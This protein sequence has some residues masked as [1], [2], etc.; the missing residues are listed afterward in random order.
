MTR[1]EM[2]YVATNALKYNGES[3]E[4]TVPT[5]NIPD[6]SSCGAYRASV[7]FAYSTGVLMGVDASGAFDPNGTLSR[8]AAATVAVR[9]VDKSFRGT[10]NFEV[11]QGVQTWTEGEQHDIPKVGDKITTKS[12]QTYTIEM[13]YGVLGAN[14]DGD[15][16]SGVSINGYPLRIG[17]TAYVDGT[18]LVKDDRTGQVHS[19]LEWKKIQK[20]AAPSGMVG[21]YDGE[22]YNDWY[23]WNSEL[24][25]W[26]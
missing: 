2:A 10:P 12:G 8:A 25:R 5:S 9:L 24:S 13:E 26:Q 6:Y 22:V 23:K 4:R 17:G 18:T 15:I 21:D 11:P 14:V 16:W 20:E 1:A 19:T 3:A 7:L